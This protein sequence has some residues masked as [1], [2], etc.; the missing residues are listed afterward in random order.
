MK[1]INRLE[2]TLLAR[3][4]LGLALA[5]GCGG[6]TSA[7]P[8]VGG[9]T[10]FLRSCSESCGD[11][12]ACIGGI[13]TRSCLVAEASCDDLATGA[14]CTAASVEPGAV[15]VCDLAC[16]GA[17]DCS[18]LGS[19]Y[20]CDAGFC[21]APA[22]ASLP[23][24]ASCPS[25]AA[26]VL[27]PTPID[28][29]SRVIPGASDVQSA[30]ADD[31]GLYWMDR[32]GVIFALRPGAS[33]AEQ[34]SAPPAAPFVLTGFVM[35]DDN[36]Y[37]GE[38]VQPQ[39]PV[40]PGPPSPPGRLNTVSKAGGFTVELVQSETDVFAPLGVRNGQVIVDVQ[41][42]DLGIFGVPIVGVQREPVRLRDGFSSS[43]LVLRGDDIY[44]SEG[45]EIPTLRRAPL[46]GG[47]SQLVS[48]IEEGG[49]FAVGPGVV[50]W[51]KSTTTF[52]PLTLVESLVLLDEATGCVSD[53][54]SLGETISI[55]GL[56]AD[57][58]YWKSYN[59]LGAFS[60]GDV[61]EALPLVRVNLRT[62][63]F[64]RLSTPGFDA[65]I[66][67]DYLA[68]DEAALYFRVDGGIVA[69]QKP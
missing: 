22:L 20:A 51:K 47:P 2:R 41:V 28:S 8:V 11:G 54:P 61:P 3:G 16:A 34:L 44:Y 27:T 65:T 62:G 50:L 36:L 19:G 45:G 31:T 46:A 38:A 67:T 4:L 48:L 13:C 9:E 32:A 69:V 23:P 39:G 15:A 33:E 42:G 21:R 53:L 64:E 18:A 57:H 26:G 5:V 12:L 63:A 52:D 25:F 66:F 7:T 6:A 40:E 60:S 49:G 35:D 14:T 24:G 55:T 1:H 10:H 59:G 37:W 43:P 29:S 17:G 56:D 30:I 58:V 68:E